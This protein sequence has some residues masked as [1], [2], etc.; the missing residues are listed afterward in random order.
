MITEKVY[1]PVED[2]NIQTN[3]GGS[4][5]WKECYKEDEITDVQK[6]LWTYWIKFDCLTPIQVNKLFL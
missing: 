3:I 2:K 5:I 1:S 4:P 6:A